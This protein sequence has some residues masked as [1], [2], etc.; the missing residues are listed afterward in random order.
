MQKFFKMVRK[1]LRSRN[2]RKNQSN[3]LKYKVLNIKWC[4]NYITT[5]RHTKEKDQIFQDRHKHI[6]RIMYMLKL[7]SKINWGKDRLPRKWHQNNQ[8][9]I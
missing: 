9:N 7:V 5:E 3:I 2:M 6:T 4:D 8:E 1:I